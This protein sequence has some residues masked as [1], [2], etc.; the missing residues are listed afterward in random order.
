MSN[1]SYKGSELELFEKAENWKAYYRNLIKDYLGQEVL[2]VG[3]GIGATTRA[4]H[5]EK[6]TRWVCLEPDPAMGQQI[7][8]LIANHQLP[9][10]CEVRVGLVSELQ[11][12]DTF[13]TV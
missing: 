7:R 12:E 8:S 5:S 11:T 3:A 6:Q 2:E 10:S 9:S 4:L 1:L 13:D